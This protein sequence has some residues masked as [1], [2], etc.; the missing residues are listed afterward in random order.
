[1]CFLNSLN[2]FKPFNYFIKIYIAL[3]VSKFY[4]MSPSNLP[5]LLGVFMGE[6]QEIRRSTTTITNH[7]RYRRFVGD[8]FQHGADGV[9]TTLQHHTDDWNTTPL[10]SIGCNNDIKSFKNS[11]QTCSNS[12][13]NTIKL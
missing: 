3:G 7:H 9:G 1:M 13:K 12:L 11:L 2:L 5:I 4:D 8:I 10:H 6:C